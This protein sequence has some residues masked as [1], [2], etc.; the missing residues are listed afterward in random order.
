MKNAWFI[1][2][3]VILGCALT[4]PALAQVARPYDQESHGQNPKNSIDQ[5]QPL[6]RFNLKYYRGYI[7]SVG[8]KYIL[9]SPTNIIYLLDNQKEA[10]AYAGRRVVVNGTLDLKTNTIHVKSIVM[11]PAAGPTP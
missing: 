3:N 6:Q 11:M 8:G 4:L 2:L 1:L 7:H 5:D 9:T 10:R